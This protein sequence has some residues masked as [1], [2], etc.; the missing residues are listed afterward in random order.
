MPKFIF[1]F[2][3]HDHHVGHRKK[4][5]IIE[6][7][8]MG[9]SIVT[10]QPAPVH[11]Q[12]YRELLH[13]HIM[14]DLVI[15]PLHKGRIYGSY[16]LYPFRSQTGRKSYRMLFRNT[17]IEKTFRKFTGKRRYPGSVRHGSCNRNN[18]FILL[19]QFH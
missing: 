11:T 18:R 9:I 15:G 16:G 7:P 19:R 5:S 4:V 13:T 12:L 6:N 2:R 8:V 3:R 14:E 10:D 1:I 17:Y